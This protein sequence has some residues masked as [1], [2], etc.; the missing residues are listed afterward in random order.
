MF[1]GSKGTADFINFDFLPDEEYS[2]TATQTNADSHNYFTL[3]TRGEMVCR[4][5]A[6]SVYGNYAWEL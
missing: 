2:E 5:N 3:E 1:A 4:V 6:A